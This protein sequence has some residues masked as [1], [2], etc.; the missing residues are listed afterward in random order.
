MS[1]HASLCVQFRLAPPRILCF[2]YTCIHAARLD[3]G[4]FDAKLCGQSVWPRMM[5]P[6]PRVASSYHHATL[7][8]RSQP[9][10]APPRINTVPYLCIII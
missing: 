8:K 3:Q 2:V 9:A 6:H 4:V 1:S 5:H 7:L 10:H